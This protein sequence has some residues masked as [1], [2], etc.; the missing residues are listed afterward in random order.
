[1]VLFLISKQITRIWL[2]LIKLYRVTR[3]PSNLFLI[4]K[5]K[6]IYTVNDLKFLVICMRNCRPEGFY[7]LYLQKVC[8]YDGI[9]ISSLFSYSKMNQ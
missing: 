8:T 1:M 4:S 7:L 9:K 3:N 5:R 2:K 6:M